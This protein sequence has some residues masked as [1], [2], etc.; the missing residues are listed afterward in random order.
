MA[1][2]PAPDDLGAPDARKGGLLKGLLAWRAIKLMAPRE[3]I[4]A[5]GILG[6]SLLSG[7]MEMAIVSLVAP[8]VYV[9]VDPSNFVQSKLGAYVGHFVD[10]D[11]TQ[12]AVGAL[13]SAVFAALLMAAGIRLATIYASEKHSAVC[14]NRL[15]REILDKL[16]E[17]PVEWSERYS[18]GTKLNLLTLDVASWRNDF[19]N[20]I[21]LLQQSVFMIMLP[22]LA[23]VAIATVQGLGAIAAIALLVAA[24]IAVFRRGIRTAS[25]RVVVARN[26]AL[27]RLAQFL[28]GL[29]EIKLSANRRF[30]TDRFAA[31]SR[32][33]ADLG[34]VARLWASSPGI[35]IHTLG[36]IG[37]LA[38]AFVFWATADSA[39]DAAA[40]L[41]LMAVFFARVLP[42]FNAAGN[43]V[44]QLFRAAPQ[45]DAIIATIA[46]LD[47]ATTPEPRA[48]RV[49]APEAWRQI[50]FERVEKIYRGAERCALALD[51]VT[52]ERGK[53]YGI[54]GRSGSGKSTLAGIISGLIEPTTGRVTVDGTALADIERD[55][56]FRG[57]GYVAQ[58]P[59]LLDASLEENVT[60][61]ATEDPKKLERTLADAS[62]SMFVASLER[63]LQTAVGER[64]S[65][66]SGGQI[67]RIAIA[68]ALYRRPR[69][70]IF[71][72]AT[73]ALD[74]ETEREIQKV[75]TDRDPGRLTLIVAHRIH[76]LS[77]CDEILVLED[78]ALAD[79]GTY[80]YLA[81]NSPIFMAMLAAAPTVAA[82]ERPAAE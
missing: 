74:N 70:L 17:A 72:E 2:Q 82:P 79:R 65:R 5:V 12:G 14:R 51:G 11:N 53:I 29:R 28:A 27:Q 48:R 32:Q 59:F 22:A 1:K 43:Q 58:P 10:I 69:F 34:V 76:T 54:V 33:V 44:A 8:I 49:S 7:V 61:G 64:G 73:S 26:K 35:L 55:S 60:F 66:L 67:Q 57:I 45:V 39:A 21:L 37:F 31:D 4:G 50:R 52:F 15:S 42:S 81:A 25:G 71:D 24:V 75:L 3:R 38:T 68:R 77:A 56:W 36:Q 16:I 30:F 80:Q 62:L 23:V 20:N 47:R 18:T 46:A 40:H 78:G 13:G 6:L 9:I 41:A 63:G 19:L